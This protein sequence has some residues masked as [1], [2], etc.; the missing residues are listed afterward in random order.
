MYRVHHHCMRIVS[1]EIY[2]HKQVRT[3]SKLVVH[4]PEPE[5]V[6]A[7]LDVLMVVQCRRRSSLQEAV[8]DEVGDKYEHREDLD[9]EER[10]GAGVGARNVARVEAGRGIGMLDDAEAEE[11]GTKEG[12]AE[13]KSDEAADDSDDDAGVEDIVGVDADGY[14]VRD[15]VLEGALLGLELCEGVNAGGEGNGTPRTEGS[16]SAAGRAWKVVAVIVCGLVVR[17]VCLRRRGRALD[18]RGLCRQAMTYQ[19]SVD[20]HDGVYSG[21]IL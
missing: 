14:D 9:A 4:G 21:S 20:T 10:E 13:D 17:V 5:R 6:R 2:V 12:E 11:A 1:Q 18:W 7:R 3:V 8:C 16:F 19:R 15:G